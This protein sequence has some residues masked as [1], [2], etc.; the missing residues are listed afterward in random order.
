MN[1]IALNGSDIA[2]YGLALTVLVLVNALLI[3]LG[4][5]IYAASTKA[6]RACSTDK[7]ELPVTSGADPVAL[8]ISI[9]SLR[10]LVKRLESCLEQLQEQRT[11][12]SEHQQLSQ[13]TFEV[14]AKLSSQG[15]D[16]AEIVKICG[17][18]QGEVEL[19]QMLQSAD[20][21]VP[22]SLVEK[23]PATQLKQLSTDGMP[24]YA[25]QTLL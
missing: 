15:A 24:T 23:E 6:S 8:H 19:I 10:D 22:R 2:L 3:G 4:Y 7:E 14:A 18:T 12:I 21:T 16:A 17:L 20:N 5:L 11:S 1:N 9:D 13:R 25:A